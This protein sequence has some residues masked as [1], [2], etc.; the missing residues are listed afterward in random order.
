M[1]VVFAVG[2]DWKQDAGLFRPFFHSRIA[3]LFSYE[4][5]R[6]WSSS[7][8]AHFSDGTS[9]VPIISLKYCQTIAHNHTEFSLGS[10]CNEYASLNRFLSSVNGTE[11]MTGTKKCGCHFIFHDS[12]KKWRNLATQAKWQVKIQSTAFQSKAAYHVWQ[13]GLDICLPSVC[14]SDIITQPYNRALERGGQCWNKAF[15]NFLKIVFS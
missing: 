10:V 8:A 6:I 7:T 13:E 5:G 1:V 12:I 11:F 4:K 9:A 14:M 15:D 2:S 3:F